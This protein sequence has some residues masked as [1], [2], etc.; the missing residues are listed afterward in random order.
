MAWS[1]VTLSLLLLL[2]GTVGVLSTEL[3]SSSS[4]Y[5]QQQLADR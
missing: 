2:F 3:E 4:E 1:G 5:E